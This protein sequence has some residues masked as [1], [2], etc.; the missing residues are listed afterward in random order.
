[1]TGSNYSADLFATLK[2]NINQKENHFR[3]FSLG[4]IPLMVLSNKCVLHENKNDLTRFKEDSKEV[5]GFFIVNGLEKI[6]RNIIIPKKNF[7]ISVIR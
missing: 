5:G 3:S 6:L 7:P 1:M 4:S 2:I